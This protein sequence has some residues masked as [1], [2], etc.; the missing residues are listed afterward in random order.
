MASGPAVT[1]GDRQPRTRP[2]YKVNV[3][4]KGDKFRLQFDTGWTDRKWKTAYEDAGLLLSN[5]KRILHS[6]NVDQCLAVLQIEP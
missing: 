5:V 6:N 2:R 1:L 4:Y 3:P